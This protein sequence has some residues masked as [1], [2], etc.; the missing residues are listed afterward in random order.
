[1]A[2]LAALCVLAVATPASAGI[3]IPVTPIGHGPDR[4]F[5][6]DCRYVSRGEGGVAD[7]ELRISA[8][9]RDF[10]LVGI[11]DRDGKLR[12][13][14]TDRCKGRAKPRLDNIDSIALNLDRSPFAFVSISSAESALGPG[15]TRE[16]DGS[17]EIEVTSNHRR[18][19]LAMLLGGADDSVASGPVSEETVATNLTAGVDDD[20]DVRTP[21]RAGVEILLGDGDDSFMADSGQ[22]RGLTGAFV[23]GGVSVSGDSGDDTLTGGVNSDFLGGGSGSD[24][25]AGRGGFDFIDGG[26]DDDELEGNGTTDFIQAKSG[27]DD[28]LG[29][30]GDD[31]IEAN[32]ARSDRV[33][34][35]DDKDYA[36]VDRRR[37]TYQNCERLKTGVGRAAEFWM[38]SQQADT[39]RR[40]HR[41]FRSDGS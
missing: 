5:G 18:V 19:P 39:V 23:Q 4:D 3:P 26:E 15:A 35:G 9:R 11:S 30:G 24:V 8:G 17:S 13:R 22:V 14:G 33:D 41:L 2:G 27:A 36:S 32:D 6:V 21:V 16:N 1:V 20:V 38:S 37:D 29:G 12:L 28:V 40:A 10:A 34:C 25:I 31:F 7:N